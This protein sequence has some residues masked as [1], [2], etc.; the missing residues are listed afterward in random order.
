MDAEYEW[1]EEKNQ[2]N[3]AKHGIDFR[4]AIQVFKDETALLEKND[5]VD[6]EQRYS[7]TGWVGFALLVFV[8]HVVRER[9]GREV[10][11]VISARPATRQERKR[12]EEQNED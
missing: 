4:A 3:I 7:I 12:Y 10:Y 8:V 5:Y 11:R 1:D 2:R 6:G 9:D